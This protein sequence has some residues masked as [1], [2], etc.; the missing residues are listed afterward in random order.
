MPGRSSKTGLHGGQ[1]AEKAPRQ[2]GVVG[3]HDAVR[4]G[5]HAGYI[6]GCREADNE[7][8]ISRILSARPGRHSSSASQNKM[9]GTSPAMTHFDIPGRQAA[10][11]SAAATAFSS[12]P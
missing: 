12:A 5:E 2:A 1:P 11:Y 9:A 8:R 10:A 4:G 6:A 3:K 7:E